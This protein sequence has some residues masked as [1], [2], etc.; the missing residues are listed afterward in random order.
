VQ[1][2]VVAQRTLDSVQNICNAQLANQTQFA[3]TA[4]GSLLAPPLACCVFTHDHVS[5]CMVRVV[6]LQAAYGILPCLDYLSAVAKKIQV[7][8]RFRPLTTDGQ[9][10]AGRASGHA[11]A[12]ARTHAMRSHA[13]VAPSAWAGLRRS[14][15]SLERKPCTPAAPAVTSP[16]GRRGDHGCHTHTHHITHT[17]PHPHTSHRRAHPGDFDGFLRGLPGAT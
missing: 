9:R 16:K 8:V 4:A 13:A 17:H 15:S 2:T 3:A 14:T 5:Y 7:A 6:L 12:R 11:R 10:G 1:R